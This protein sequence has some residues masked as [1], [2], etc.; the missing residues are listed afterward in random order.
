M[1]AVTMSPDIA[2]AERLRLTLVRLMRTLRRHGRS[3]LT[4]SQVSALS[5]LE[6]C[7]PMRI[8]AL[9]VYESLGPSAATRVVA[10]LE[11]LDL[12]ER[13]V[14]PED[15]RASLIS[16]SERGHVEFGELK[17]ERTL[18]ISSLLERLSAKERQAIEAA[19]PALEKI[20]RDG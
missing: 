9:A 3:R 1:S 14:D 4:P 5:T 10:S 7:G 16:M 19:L 12:L 20:A 2:S 17:R 18:E 8:S 15:K 13:S 6:E 11:E